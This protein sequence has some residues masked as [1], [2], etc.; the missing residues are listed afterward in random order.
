MTPNDLKDRSNADLNKMLA[1]L[2]GTADKYFVKKRGMYYRENA[3]GYTCHAFDAWI[4]PK[5]E[6]LK[7]EY[8]KGQPDEWVTI[9]QAPIPRYASNV[10]L[11][12]AIEATLKEEEY[13]DL[14]SHGSY[15]S[16]QMRYS[17]HLASLVVNW[18]ERVGGAVP[19]AR[20]FPFMHADARS[21]VIALICTLTPAHDSN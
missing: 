3:R 21:R 12:W 11:C 13:T 14:S 6:A 9:E 19:Y 5:E 18:E 7:H 17:C 1:E 15:Y 2:L 4:L 10:E 8:K 16:Q 20:L